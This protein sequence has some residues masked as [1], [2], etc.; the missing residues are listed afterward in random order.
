MGGRNFLKLVV[1]Y[2]NSEIILII[3]FKKQIYYKSKLTKG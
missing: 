2:M 1:L 3:N